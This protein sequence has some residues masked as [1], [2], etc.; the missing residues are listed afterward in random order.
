MRGESRDQLGAMVK[1][2]AAMN[3]AGVVLSGGDSAVRVCQ[4]A[5]VS[6]LRLLGEVDTGVPWGNCIGGDFDGVPAV[7][8]SGGFGQADTLLR[9]ARFLTRQ[10]DGR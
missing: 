9:V 5:Q 10:E 8:K 2:V 4:V 6:A 1:T 3:P 7:L